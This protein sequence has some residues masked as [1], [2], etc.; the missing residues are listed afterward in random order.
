MIEVGNP[1]LTAGIRECWR[2]GFTLEDPR[3]IDFFFRS[4]FQPQYG[5]AET[6]NGKVAASI[7]RIPHAM[8]FNGRV[9]SVSM[10]VGMATLPE[11][12]GQGRM[13]ELMDTVLDACSHSEL[14]TLIHTDHPSFYEEWGFHNIYSRR[15][16]TLSRNE[17]KR[18]TNFGCAYEPSPIDM[19]KVYA[20][21]IRRFNGFYA[22]DLDYFVRL[23]KEVAA[24]SGKIVA[25]YDAKNVIQ[26]YAVILLK[27]REASIEECVYLDSLALNKLINA[28][29]QERQSVH[30]HVSQAENLGV[31][32]PQAPCALEPFISVRLNDAQLFSRLFSE[33]VETVE[34]AF[35]IS[36]GPLNL[37]EIR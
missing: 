26:G 6:E 10:L 1:T 16:Y 14:L 31:L 28:A 15:D 3:Y 13:H 19:L 23:K 9:L 22:R 25:Y 32:F 11:Y 24:Q 34:D 20:S 27:G 30:L 18:I 12:R 4:I 33:H 36:A 35:G 8:M 5:Y 21:F 7:C 17:V 29:L 37:N 2:K